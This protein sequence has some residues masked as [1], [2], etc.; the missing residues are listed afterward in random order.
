MDLDAAYELNRANWDERVGVH[1]GPRGYDISA[2]RAGQGRLNALE[3]VELPDLIGELPGLRVIHLQCHFGADTLALAQRGAEVVGVDFSAAAVAAARDLAADLGLAERARFVEC[4]LYDAPDAVGEA[5]SFDLVYTTW[6][7]I[8]WLPDIAG[9]ARVVRHFLK[10]GG[11]LYFLDSHPAA[12]V[13]D[14]LARDAGAAAGD[15][16]GWFVPY[17]DTDPL[18]LDD[19][20]DYADDEA[21]LD[22]ARTVVWMHTISALVSALLEAG[23]ELRA[24]R[25]HDAVAWRMFHCLESGEDGM[26]RW[27]DRP[28]LPLS[29]TVLAEARRGG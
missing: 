1:M 11:R 4:N 17:F 19:P 15:R 9:W 27:P 8:G 7:T 20:T 12:L 5:G 6:G 18:T 22:H 3:E 2:L 14:D 24:L 10:P 28:W 25:E 23:L 16:P 26:Y 29:V 21:R 13:F